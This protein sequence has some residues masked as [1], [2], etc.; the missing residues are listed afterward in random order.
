MPL[1]WSIN[2]AEQVFEVACNGLID[3][4]EIHKMLD[5]LVGSEALGYRKLFDGTRGDTTIGA[6]DILQ[7][8]A[9]IRA[10]HQSGAALGPVAVVLPDDKYPLLSRVLGMLSI[11]KR[12]FKVFS[13]VPKAR[14]WLYSFPPG[15]T[16]K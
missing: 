11:P 10:L 1:H 15:W 14:A 12:P 13:D 6:L 16:A 7:F 8:G 3:A 5:V 2:S 9:R 4:P